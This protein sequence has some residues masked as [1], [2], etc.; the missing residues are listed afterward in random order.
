MGSGDLGRLYGDKEILCREGD[1]GDHMFVIQQGTVEVVTANGGR[2]TSLARLN[3]GA[4]IGEIAIFEK[5]PRSATVRAVG[6]VRALTVDRKN[7]L[8]RVSEDPTLALRVIRSLSSR[9]RDLS[10]KVRDLN[11]ELAKLR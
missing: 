4:I 11:D 3:E 10:T 9:V 7:L 1:K 6:E 2:E 8:K 5:V